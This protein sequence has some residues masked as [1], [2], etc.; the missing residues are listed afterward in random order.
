M[1]LVTKV[2]IAAC[3]LAL[4][5]YALPYAADAATASTNTNSKACSQVTYCLPSKYAGWIVDG[6]PYSADAGS[7]KPLVAA[8][9]QIGMFPGCGADFSG[10]PFTA[11][12]EANDSVTR[13]FLWRRGANKGNWKERAL[14][15][16]TSVAG[17]LS[18]QATIDD[19]QGGLVCVVDSAEAGLGDAGVA[20]ILSHDGGL[21]VAV[22]YA[23]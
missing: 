16:S 9:N 1:N 17:G 20:E 7:G 10:M 2:T 11:H 21:K 8:Q 12:A 13:Y 23:Q 19:V 6:G 18:Y 5:S 3:I 14:R 15:R 4:L 22:E